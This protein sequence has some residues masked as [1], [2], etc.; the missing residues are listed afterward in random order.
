M[1]VQREAPVV[2]NRPLTG[3][4]WLLDVEVP[5]IAGPLQ[6][7]QFVNIRAGAATFVRRPFSVYRV[8]ADRRRL[9]VAYKRV[10]AGTQAMT[11]LRPGMVCDLIGPL[12]K[13]FSLPAGAARI[14]LVGRG[15]GIAA[16]PTLMDAA[17]AAG[18]AMRGF[19]SAR[20]RRNL[21]ALDIFAELGAPV[22]THTDEDE[23][24]RLVTDLLEDAAR[25]VAFD[26]FYVCGSKRL[27]R[28]IEAMAR[29][30]G[31]LA[32]AAMEQHMACGF[33]DCHGCVI[34]VNR[35][36]DARE[37]VDREVCH[38]GPVFNAWE[39]VDA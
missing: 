4:Y 24:G 14:A 7:G 9:Q 3:D 32:E 21:V 12:G 29:R 10:G 19:L 2:E 30:A 33:G 11:G 25:S 16:L 1:P 5:E 31:V 23:P 18:I 34:A 39:V 22:A 15:I 35:D 17:A 6:P 38:Y 13:G 20:D 8:S 37:R 36:R 27:V 28:A 26:A